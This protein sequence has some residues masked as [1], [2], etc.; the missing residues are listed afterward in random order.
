M[1]IFT[2]FTSHAAGL[3][4]AVFSL[5]VPLK[6]E[7]QDLSFLSDSTNY[8]WPTDASTYISSTFGE[9]RSR[10]FHAGLDIRT[11]G[12]EGY[13]VFATRDGIV[14]RIAISPHGY[15]KVIFLK[16]DDDSYSIYAH[17]NRFEDSL[18][19]VADSIRLQDYRFVLDRNMEHKQIRVKQGDLIGFTG[20]TGVGPPHLHFELRTP[21][22]EPFNPLLTNISVAD[23]IPPV[24]AGLAVEHLDPQSYHITD[25]ETRRAQQTGSGFSFGTIKTN[26]PVGLSVNVHDRANRTPN[27]Y[28]VYGLALVHEQDTLFQSNVDAFSYND[29]SQ[30][31]IDR[32]YPLLKE[33]RQGFQRLYI[34]NG[35]NL[36][37]YHSGQTRGVVDLPEGTHRLTIIAE[38]Y[39][40]NKTRGIL[41]LQV[42][43][44][45]SPPSVSVA[46]IPAYP[47]NGRYDSRISESVFAGNFTRQ[48]NA[49]MLTNHTA[50]LGPGLEI[51]PFTAPIFHSSE[52]AVRRSGKKLVPGK[53]QFLHLSDQTI[54]IEFPQDALF[55]TLQLEMAVSY[56]DNLPVIR[57]YPE[58]IPLKKDA[59]INIV[60]PGYDEN[61]QPAGIYSYNNR[62]SR[63]QFHGAGKPGTILQASISDLQD[64]MV[65]H[66]HT[67]PFV[68]P[69]RIQKNLAGM[70]VVN[71]PVVDEMSG[72]DFRRS[73][74]EV[75]GEKGITEYDPDK[76]KLIFYKPGFQPRASNDVE[77]WV[78]DGIGNLSHRVFEGVN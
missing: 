3:L 43:D 4:V 37:F 12:R 65:L 23:D 67:S 1:W 59:R 44:R 66:D 14:H 39:Y 8:L 45:N 41:D 73:R 69:P 7:S 64:F 27:V 31:F 35:N 48:F 54:W 53:R 50:S 47:K 63:Y 11:W 51:E 71:V 13:Q 21:N 62:R 9:T 36:P 18:M 20:S 78:F 25:T 52:S 40:G 22:N 76:N 49:S 68:G 38:D 61:S 60:L 33:R 16:H 74:I 58:N 6:A 17:L 30:M 57:F 5:L 19:A 15:G 2:N 55:D 46:S 26:G 42:S 10:H 32:V 77:V 56:K 28:A 24:F 34:V 72:I 29:A 75:N 70:H